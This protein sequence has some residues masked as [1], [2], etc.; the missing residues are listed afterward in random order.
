MNIKDIM[1]WRGLSTHMTGKPQ[2]IRKEK[3]PVKYKT[4]I[5]ELEDLIEYWMKRN[6]LESKKWKKR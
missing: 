2:N 5:I 1:N 4:A 3:I 6:N